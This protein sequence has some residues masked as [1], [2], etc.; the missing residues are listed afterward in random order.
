MSISLGAFFDLV[1]YAACDLANLAALKGFPGVMDMVWGTVL[2][3][4]V[5]TVGCLVAFRGAP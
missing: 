1:A 2:S 5:V 4:S 3:A